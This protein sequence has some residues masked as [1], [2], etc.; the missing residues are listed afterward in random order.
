M[1][2]GICGART[3][4]VV[5]VVFV[6]ALAA[7]PSAQSPGGGFDIITVSARPDFVSGGDVL[8]RVQVPD[9]VPLDE[10][11]VILNGADVTG[12]FHRDDGDHSFTGL[13]TGLTVGTNTLSVGGGETGGATLAVVN[14]P[15]VG[16]VFCR[17]GSSC[18]GAPRATPARGDGGA[19][20]YHVLTLRDG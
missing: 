4:V 17:H 14:H 16:P 2:M 11:R 5:G 19:R 8:V 1:H 15:I 3:A 18:P 7:W 12:A 10:P 13:V 6:L 9:T 20:R